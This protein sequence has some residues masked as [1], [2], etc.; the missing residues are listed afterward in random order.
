MAPGDVLG[1]GGRRNARGRARENRIRR[2]QPVELGV[3]L[4]L[5]LDPLGRAFLDM[6]GAVQRLGEPRGVADAPENGVRVVDQPE[7]CEIRE[8]RRDGIPRPLQGRGL[9]VV[10]HDLMTGAAEH[11]RPRLPDQAAAHQ[12]DPLH[13]CLP[14]LRSA[15]L[16]AA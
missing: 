7:A 13:G 6:G 12:C 10:Q 11:D 9:G 2:G 4:A 5:H 14:H 8:A 15:P 3:Q 1:E 16:A